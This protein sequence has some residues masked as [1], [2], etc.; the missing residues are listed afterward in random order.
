MQ[1]IYH[2]VPCTDYLQSG[3]WYTARDSK[4]KTKW[5]KLTENSYKK[6]KTKWI[7]LTENSYKKIKTKWIELTENS[8]K[9]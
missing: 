3:T 6:I 2:K 7:E 9:K 4:I 1:N 5:I 8:Y